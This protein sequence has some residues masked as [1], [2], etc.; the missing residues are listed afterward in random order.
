MTRSY[1]RAQIHLATCQSL[2]TG[3]QPFSDPLCPNK[4][5]QG[6]YD[7]VEMESR[8]HNLPLE[9]VLQICQALPLRSIVCVALTSRELYHAQALQKLWRSR[10]TGLNPKHR[11][12]DCPR[13]LEARAFKLRSEETDML[14]M[15][16]DI[17]NH[18]L[19]LTLE[20]LDRDL[21]EHWLCDLCMK[22]HKRVAQTEDGLTYRPCTL[23]QSNGLFYRLAPW[24][25]QFQF[26]DAQ[27]VMKR[28]IHGAPH[29]LPFEIIQMDQKWESISDWSPR[30]LGS[31]EPSPLIWKKSIEVKPEIVFSSGPVL[32]LWTK[33]RLFFP[34]VYI[35]VLGLR[36]HDWAREIGQKAET[37]FAICCHANDT[38]RHVAA[39]L[40]QPSRLC[41]ASPELRRCDVC[42]TEYA[43]F[44][45]QEYNKD[46]VEIVLSTWT[47]LGSCKHSFLP[48]WLTSSWLTNELTWFGERGP[49]AFP[50]PFHNNTSEFYDH[51]AFRRAMVLARS[52]KRNPPSDM[53]GRLEPSVSKESDVMLVQT[54]SDSSDI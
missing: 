8:P 51:A 11:L 2:S 46:S 22:L 4:H 27:Q 1:P 39:L 43:F 21:P 36:S 49:F 29:G 6:S 28:Y 48:A 37:H 10:L 33:Q 19:L 14:Y 45:Y 12:C 16:T 53:I 13:L 35:G 31:T 18:E 50:K 7:V 26:E 15:R 23:S 41:R 25:Y 24:D 52:T 34:S 20:L 17:C 9:V 42:L 32:T 54:V 40:D 44:V 3:A 47:S 5:F 38:G 30:A